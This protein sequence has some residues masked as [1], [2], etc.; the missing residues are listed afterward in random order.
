MT[1]QEIL[2]MKNLFQDYKGGE[3]AN[4]NSPDDKRTT[5]SA[6]NFNSIKS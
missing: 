5:A 3:N 1:T 4:N 6:L 2:T